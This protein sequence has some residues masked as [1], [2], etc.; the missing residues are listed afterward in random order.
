[1]TIV[2]YDTPSFLYAFNRS[3]VCFHQIIALFSEE[4][5][6]AH[7]RGLVSPRLT[8]RWLSSDHLGSFIEQWL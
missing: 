2:N 7:Y 6:G 5:L 1:M 4:P 3:F 8:I